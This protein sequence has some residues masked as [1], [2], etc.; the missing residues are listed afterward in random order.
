MKSPHCLKTPAISG[1]SDDRPAAAGARRWPGRRAVASA[2]RVTALC[3]LS[4]LLACTGIAMFQNHLL[5]FP[6]RAGVGE[7]TADGLAPWPGAGDFRGLLAEPAGPA[8][9][10][11]I[12][13][14][15]NA[16]HAGHRQ[17]YS[18]ALVPLG[19]RVILAE[20]PAYGPRAG[21]LGE[22]SLVADAERTI[23]LAH[24]RYGG[25]LL[26]IGE[27]LGAGVAAAASARQRAAIG[28]LL[29]ITP[30]DRL[31]NVASHHYPLLPVKLLLRDR[32]DSSSHLA[33][34]QR[35]V[36]VAVAA[37]DRIVPARFGHALYDSLPQ[38]KRLALIEG[39]DHNDWFYRLDENWWRQAIDFLLAVRD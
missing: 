9:A 20:Y 5:Y 27:S 12:V 4:Y 24:E 15:G 3:I 19:L 17:F 21:E 1:A 2:L 34:L 33:D 36:L 14:H 25:P 6:Q 18:D 35:P 29:L 37:D 8:R 7:M 11:A 39:A 31:E 32:Y 16:G 13:F 28:G 26:I 23:A 22:T 10:T 38:P 30:W